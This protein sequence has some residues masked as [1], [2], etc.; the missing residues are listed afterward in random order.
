MPAPSMKNS[1]CRREEDMF[2][3]AHNFQ[4]STR[5]TPCGHNGFQSDREKTRGSGKVNEFKAQ[6]DIC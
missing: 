4:M 2:H 5:T 1:L 3:Y 6:R